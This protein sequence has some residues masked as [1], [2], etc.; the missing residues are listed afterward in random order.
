MATLADVENAIVGIVAGALFPGTTY[1]PLSYAAS[2]LGGLTI[3]VYRGWPDADRLNKDLA[4]GTAHVSVFPDNITRLMTRFLTDWEPSATVA[5][6]S[7]TVAVVGNVVT[8]GGAAT[9]GQAAGIALGDAPYL[10]TWTYRPMAGDTPAK[11]AAAFA[12]MIP[13][14][15]ASGAVLTIDEAALG[16]DFFLDNSTLA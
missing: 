13:G 10:A 16:V 5:A 1:K 8:F 6:P 2:V 7:L 15:T 9:P 3:K 4:A 14:A 12:A 11:V